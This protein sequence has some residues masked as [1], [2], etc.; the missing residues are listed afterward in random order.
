MVIASI[1]ADHSYHKR[2]HHKLSSEK[3]KF[4]G[5]TKRQLSNRKTPNGHLLTVVTKKRKY[6]KRSKRNQGKEAKANLDEIKPE[7]T[8]VKVPRGETFMGIMERQSL[9]ESRDAKQEWEMYQH[10][11]AVITPVS[12]HTRGVSDDVSITLTNGQGDD[13]LDEC[14]KSSPSAP[15]MEAK[16]VN[17]SSI[18]HQLNNPDNTAIYSI[19]VPEW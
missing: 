18:N 12:D 6:G 3:D 5:I 15:F 4:L 16:F 14:F 17:M 1:L 19:V 11:S 2:S 10:V 8:T 7:I 9:P 13:E